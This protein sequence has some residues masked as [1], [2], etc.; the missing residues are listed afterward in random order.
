MTEGGNE[1]LPQSLDT[2]LQAALVTPF[3]ASSFGAS[4]FL[5]MTRQGGETESLLDLMERVEGLAEW[6]KSAVARHKI[7]RIPGQRFTSESFERLS[8]FMGVVQEAFHEKDLRPRMKKAL[9]SSE[10]SPLVTIL[11]NDGAVLSTQQ[12]N[13]WHTEHR[14]RPLPF[15]DL[16]LLFLDEQERPSFTDFIMQDLLFEKIDRN[17]TEREFWERVTYKWDYPCEM[18]GDV[19]TETECV[20]GTRAFLVPVVQ[21]HPITGKRLFFLWGPGVYER[22]PAVGPHFLLSD[23]SDSRPEGAPRLIKRRSVES[24]ELYERLQSFLDSPQAAGLLVP[25]GWQRGDLVLMDNFVCAHKARQASQQSRKNA[26]LRRLL[27]SV[28]KYGE[29]STRPKERGLANRQF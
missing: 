15:P 19:R 14:E 20:N 6:L 21:K 8:S 29:I 1:L 13:F 25:F 3:N 16:T 28:V 22:A 26:G 23:S 24:K 7:L 2:F 9:M 4:L 5:P 11:S 12:G 18:F 17:A 27:R 10:H